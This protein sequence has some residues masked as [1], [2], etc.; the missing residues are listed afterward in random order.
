MTYLVI[1][2]CI[3]LLLA[4]I[5]IS[6]KPI[7]MGIEARRNI[8]Q[9]GSSDY[10]DEDQTEAEKINN[11]NISDEIIN[12]NKLKKDGVLT[13]EEMKNEK[14][15]RLSR[16][17]FFLDKFWH[18]IIFIYNIFSFLLVGKQSLNVKDNKKIFQH[19][20]TKTCIFSLVLPYTK[21]P[22]LIAPNLNFLQVQ[23][24]YLKEVT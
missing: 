19:F 24:H 5:I 11:F 2:I 8:N 7:G 1:G 3:A 13:D 16:F 4:V 17:Y 10:I 22:Q 23:N 18:I 12:L 14:I 9:K 21:Y 15:I 6:A 20:F